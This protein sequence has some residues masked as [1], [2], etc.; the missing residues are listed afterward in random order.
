MFKK[1][2]LKLYRRED[3]NLFLKNILI[4]DRFV[5]NLLKK[6]NDFKNNNFSIF[7]HFN[8]QFKEKR[9]LRIIYGISEKKYNYY[10]NKHKNRKGN[11]FKNIL[12]SFESRLDNYI[13]RIGFS[14]TRNEARQMINHNFIKLNNFICKHPSKCLKVGDF[15]SFNSKKNF[16][17]KDYF[18]NYYSNLYFPEWIFINKKNFSSYLKRLPTIFNLREYLYF[19]EDL[20]LGNCRS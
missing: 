6:N 5:Y 1:K 19:K 13:Y 11:I 3:I 12:L 10:Y 17:R 9:R 2:K 16:F 20:I 4:S 7:T 14:T 8:Y 15:I 18:E